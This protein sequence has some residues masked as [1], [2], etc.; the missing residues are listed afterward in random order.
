[1]TLRPLALLVV[2]LSCPA[3]AATTTVLNRRIGSGQTVAKALYDAGVQSAQVDALVNALSG[4]FDCRKSNAG[5]QLRLVV[6]SGEVDFFDY[7]RNALEEYQVRRDGEKLV[8]SRREVEFEKKVSTV[9]LKVGSSMWEAAL[10]AGEDPSIAMELSDVFAWDIDFYQDVQKG[11][12]VRMVVEKVISKG[13]LVRYGDLLAAKYEGSSVG[14]KQV[15]R[16]QL[17]DGSYSYFQEDGSSA[18][19]SFLKSPLKYAHIT[20]KFGSRFHPVLKY[21]K[22][23]NGVDYGAAVGTPVWAVADGTVLKATYDGAA[24]N[25]ICVRHMNGIET[26]YL[27]LSK[28][29]EGIRVG[30]RVSQKQV[31]AYSGNT[32]RTTGPHLHFAM[33]RGGG[34]VNPLN[35]NFPRADPLPQKLVPDFREKIAG[36]V[37]SLDALPVAAV[38]Q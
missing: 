27:H 15:Y 28:F 37:S 12:V 8:A 5:D 33:K 3:F 16:Y 1:M 10:T 9:E 13:R 19:K 34:F 18:R 17:P 24:G 23:H 35:Q 30:A 26:C 25:H 32:G 36:Y 29:G 11:D 20:S 7:R 22:D 6:S 38:T 14:K 4:V 2:A 21:V 31:I